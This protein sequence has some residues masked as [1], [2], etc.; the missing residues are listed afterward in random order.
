MN[1]GWAIV[2][3]VG[4]GGNGKGGKR[5]VIS[6]LGKKCYIFSFRRGPK[7]RLTN[8]EQ[9]KPNDY[10]IVKRKTRLELLCFGERSL[11]DHFFKPTFWCCFTPTFFYPTPKFVLRMID[12]STSTARITGKSEIAFSW[13]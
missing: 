9:A 12:I 5:Q 7:E 8:S 13:L 11:F 1:L 3:D 10:K 6:G 2:Q 4:F